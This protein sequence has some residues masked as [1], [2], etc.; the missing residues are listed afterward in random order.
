MPRSGRRRQIPTDFGSREQLPILAAVRLNDEP[1]SRAVREDPSFTRFRRLRLP[2][3]NRCQSRFSL[4][5]NGL[6]EETGN[7]NLLNE[8]VTRVFTRFFVGSQW[9]RSDAVGH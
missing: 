7:T 3:L 4:R 5:H 8:P 1:Q 9:I 2:D 6:R